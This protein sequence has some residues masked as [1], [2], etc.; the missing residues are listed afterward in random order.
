M[1]QG[2]FFTKLDQQQR[3]VKKDNDSDRW[4]AIGM[5]L[6]QICNQRAELQD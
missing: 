3:Q 4:L 1:A 6:Q 2:Q 5:Q